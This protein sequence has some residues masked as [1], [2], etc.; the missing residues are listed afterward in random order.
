MEAEE[1]LELHPNVIL[2][3]YRTNTI[4]NHPWYHVGALHRV[5]T[6]L[7]TA[8][9]ATAAAATGSLSASLMGGSG[10][11]KIAGGVANVAK[12]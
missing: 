8:Q 5:G 12:C 1:F 4:G 2:Q 9:G 10:M 3:V 7:S 6:L 11:Q